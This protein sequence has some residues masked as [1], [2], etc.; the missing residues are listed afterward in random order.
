MNIVDVGLRSNQTGAV[1]RQR[2]IFMDTRVF[3]EGC[4]K[5]QCSVC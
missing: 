3:I 4:F 1:S 2:S 5:R